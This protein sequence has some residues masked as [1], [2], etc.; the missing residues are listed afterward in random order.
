MGLFIFLKSASTYKCHDVKVLTSYVHIKDFRL[1]PRKSNAQKSRGSRFVC[2]EPE[3]ALA[4][5][6]LVVKGV[7]VYGNFITLA[8]EKRWQ[9]F[10]R[11]NYLELNP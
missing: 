2:H 3:G 10:R 6:F 5:G 8:E 11:E 7:I 1:K 9:F 4:L